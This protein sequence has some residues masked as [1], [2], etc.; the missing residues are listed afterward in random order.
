[1][2]I[3]NF[4]K[5]EADI[6]FYDNSNTY[7]HVTKSFF[8]NLLFKELGNRFPLRLSSTFLRLPVFLI[9]YLLNNAFLITHL[10]HHLICL[11]QGIHQQ[12][13]PL[14]ELVEV[15]LHVFLLALEVLRLFI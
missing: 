5:T 9:V 1:V 14:V 13:N 2:N 15:H 6:I 8:V 7:I 10:C 11:L 3:L 12:V 4:A